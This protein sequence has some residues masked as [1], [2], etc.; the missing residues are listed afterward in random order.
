IQA[1][2]SMT[3]NSDILSQIVSSE[4]TIKVK[5]F[6]P[7]NSTNQ[8]QTA[9]DGQSDSNSNASVGGAIGDYLK[10]I[11]DLIADIEGVDTTTTASSGN[12][13]EYISQPLTVTFSNPWDLEI[14][15]RDDKIVGQRCYYY[16]EDLTTNVPVLTLMT[17]SF[18]GVYIRSSNPF[19]ARVKVTY[20]GEPIAS[21]TVDLAVWDADVD[22]CEC[23]VKDADPD[24]YPAFTK[25]NVSEIITLPSYRVPI[26]NG[27]ESTLN[28]QGET[29]VTPVSYVDVALYAP[30]LP[31]NVKL[32][33]KGTFAG[34]SSLK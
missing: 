25:T 17:E 14:T 2:L 18:D 19:V 26:V 6:I 30:D 7:G 33:A 22:L 15:N 29:V 32:F 1:S 5:T 16:K 27:T 20:K 28:S 23:A 34:F 8:G 9:S 21:G 13:F 31:L 24:C 10:I 11:E 4:F 12:I 3:S